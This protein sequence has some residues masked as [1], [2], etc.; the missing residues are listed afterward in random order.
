MNTPRTQD[1]SSKQ[2]YEKPTLQ[3]H[4]TL[5]TIVG[6]IPCIDADMDGDCD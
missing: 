6:S 5:T 2:V 4:G 3:A 1:T